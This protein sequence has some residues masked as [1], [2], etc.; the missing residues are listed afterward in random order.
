MKKIRAFLAGFALATT[1]LL[2]AGPYADAVT[3]YSPGTG[4]S[5]GFNNSS[6][7]LGSPSTINPFTEAV[8]PFNSPYGNAQIVSLGAGGSL[9]VQFLTPIQNN[10]SNP[11]GLDFL[12]F[13]NTGFVV[14]NA[15]D[16]NFNYIGTPATDGST[17]GNNTGSTRVSVSSDG[18]TYYQLNPSLAPVVDGLYPTDGAGNFGKPVNPA[19]GNSAFA[20]KDLNGIR[21][22][23]GGS[24]GG[25]GFDIAWAQDT[26]NLPANLS[27]IGYVRVD[28]VSGKSE[29]DA[30]S[31]VSPVPEPSVLALGVFGAMAAFVRRRK[32]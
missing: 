13:G 26:N 23:Y 29:I 14:T 3:A 32:Q 22:L 20:G 30:F 8:D 6:T 21:S 27:S 19:L 18:L 15:T 2:H 4:F 5:S 7:V 17:Y 10:P 28:V 11:Y 31:V 9:T 12:I 24:G 16:A 1:P 25:T